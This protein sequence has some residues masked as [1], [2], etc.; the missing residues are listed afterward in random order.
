MKVGEFDLKTVAIG[1]LRLRKTSRHALILCAAAVV[2]VSTHFTFRDHVSFF[3]RAAGSKN[4]GPVYLS[5]EWLPEQQTWGAS[6][7]LTEISTNVVGLLFLYAAV[8]KMLYP[9]EA[10][11]AISSLGVKMNTASWCITA[12]IIIELYLGALLLLKLHLVYAIRRAHFTFLGGAG[13][14]PLKLLARRQC[15]SFVRRVGRV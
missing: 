8:S 6:Q 2:S 10:T 9:A 14:P 1:Q 5:L 7:M 12:L 3:G 15:K 13:L 4:A 11:L